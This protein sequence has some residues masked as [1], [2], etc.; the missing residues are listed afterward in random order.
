MYR[1]KVLLVNGIPHE[2]GCT[3]TALI[4]VAKTLNE[5]GIDTEIFWIDTK[6]LAGC[7]ACKNCAKTGCWVFDDRVNDFLDIVK[8]ADGF[9]FGSPVHYAAAS[10]AITSFMDRVFYT[11]LQSGKQSFYLK[12]A[13]AVV[14]ARRAGTTVTFDQLN[15][16]LPFQRCLLL[17]PAIGIWFM[18]QSRKM[19]KKIWKACRQCA[20]LQG[21]WHGS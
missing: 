14:S 4:E 1:M 3:Y 10:G 13:D 6:P 7:I 20:F 5:E 17:L 21:T 16:Y 18:E 15:K 8:D 9:I 12:P 19:W 11:D 2:K